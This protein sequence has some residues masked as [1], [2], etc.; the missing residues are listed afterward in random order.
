MQRWSHSARSLPLETSAEGTENNTPSPDNTSHTKLGGFAMTRI[1]SSL[2]LVGWVVAS[3]I[4]AQQHDHGRLDI[5]TAGQQMDQMSMMG[6]EHMRTMMGEPG[7]M[8]GDGTSGMPD[9]A[10]GGM[11]PVMM[12]IMRFQPGHLLALRTELGLTPGQITRLE[13]MASPSSMSQPA[14][15]ATPAMGARLQ[16]AF[17]AVEPDT[18]TIRRLLESR[19]DDHAQRHT[20]MVLNA[21]VARSVLTAA[22][23]SRVDNRADLGRVME[24]ETPLDSAAHHRR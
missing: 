6:C 13:A 4:A 22:Q 23:Q 5:P 20:R 8:H 24:H 16:Q 18:T 9:M 10:A 15:A 1:L 12:H 7:G 19:M 14:S 21:A 3:P 2:A 17:D 11:M